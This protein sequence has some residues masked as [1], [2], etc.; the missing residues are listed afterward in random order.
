M[1][2][3]DAR[4]TPPR[5][6]K[7][8]DVSRC[9]N[10]HRENGYEENPEEDTVKRS[11]L[12]FSLLCL[13]APIFS[14]AAAQ[15][16]AERSTPELLRY[17]KALYEQGE[18]FSSRYLFQQVLEREPENRVALAGKGQALVCE[19]S[20]D[21]GIGALEQVTQLAPQQAEPFVQL[22]SAYLEQYQHDPERYEAR[23]QDA[24]TALSRAETAG[25]DSAA[26][27]NLRGVIHYRRGDLNAARE[28]LVQA[29]TKQ[30]DVADY[31]RNLG[32]VYLDLGNAE[33]ATEVLRRAVLLEPDSALGHNQLGSAY[34]VLGRCE[35]AV[36]ELEQ[37]V[38]LAP[39]EAALNFSLG[40]ALF[41]CGSLSEAGRYLEKVVALEP[42]AFA[43]AYT[44]LA[45]IDLEARDFGGAITQ[46]TKGALLPPAN[47]EA[48]YWLGRAYQ[49]RGGTASDG[50]PDSAKAR[51]AFERALEL[52]ASYRPAQA[53]LEE[54]TNP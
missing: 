25:A 12:F 47:A 52:D 18:C 39:D 6:C 7:G 28:A 22:A 36:F 21:E 20:F 13:L 4:Q 48:Y 43:P 50:L 10:A 46:A 40:R 11:A 38:T 19:G 34:F 32:R 5:S 51:D 1:L 31:H 15:E 2:R 17:G 35:D 30:A 9:E 49:A 27:Y 3:F 8:P 29:T 41:D 37:A 33:A 45:R 42:T 44:Y 14:V 16:I 26:V 53:A 54:A 23:L 24:L